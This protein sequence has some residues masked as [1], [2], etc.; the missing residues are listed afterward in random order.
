MMMTLPATPSVPAADGTLLPGFAAPAE[1][2][3][4]ATAEQPAGLPLFAQLLDLAALA[5]QGAEAAAEAPADS[6]PAD[7]DSTG[8][9]ASGDGAAA[10]AAMMPPLAGLPLP[11]A[12]A[13]AVPA[14]PAGAAAPA[15]D[16]VQAVAAAAPPAAPL[17]APAANAALA[18]APVPAAAA[19]APA[20]PLPSAG[21]APAARAAA[22]VTQEQAPADESAP[23]P[24]AAAAPAPAAAAPLAAQRPAAPVPGSSAPRTAQPAQPQRGN[25]APAGQTAPAGTATAASA[26]SPVLAAAAKQGGHEGGS[27]DGQA[28]PAFRTLM[29]GNTALPQ[30]ADAPVTLG[31]SPEQWQQPL[32]AALGERLQLQLQRNNDQAV[33]RLEPPNMGTVEISIRHSAGSLQVNISASHSEVLRQLNQIGDSV[34]QDLSQRQYGDVAVTVSSGAGRGLADGGGSGRQEREQQERGP[35]RALSDGADSHSTFAMLT[36]RE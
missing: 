7:E 35:G 30:A 6:L 1:T 20:A 13:P 16:A 26:D 19:P 15:E 28:T 31:G 5:P 17:A 11:V 3:A 36:E 12:A 33:I 27:A 10:L 2:P 32:R 25:A 9:P 21:A 29:A 8:Q 24:A 18:Q 34:R 22:Q 23:A 14:A 4:A